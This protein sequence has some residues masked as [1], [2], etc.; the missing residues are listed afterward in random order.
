LEGGICATAAWPHAAPTNAANRT[1]VNQTRILPPR[2]SGECNTGIVRDQLGDTG[3]VLFI[4]RNQFA[5]V[6]PSPV[7]GIFS[8]GSCKVILQKINGQFLE[9]SP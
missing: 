9:A 7:R 5:D 3:I 6:L 4:A 2:L 1:P 8:H